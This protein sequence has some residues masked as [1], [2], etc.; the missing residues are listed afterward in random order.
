MRD[1]P[2]VV[3]LVVRARQGDTDAWHEIVGRYAPLIWSICRRFDLAR[4]DTDDVGGSV[5]LALVE[6]LATLREPAALPGWVATTTQRECLRIVRSHRRDQRIEEA[7]Q[8]DPRS[9][10]AFIEQEVLAEE[11]NIALRTAFAQ[12]PTQ[13]QHLLRLL[14]QDPPVTYAEISSR[15]DIPVGSIGPT[16]ARCLEKL[17][18]LP[19]LAAIL[20]P[21]D[22]PARGR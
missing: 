7:V 5:W 1:D 8:T 22:V 15:L 9:S 11:R 4:A 20:E 3:A 2:Q 10:P 16:R 21:A 6:H 17:R 12:L 13:C 14:M 18:S 19:A